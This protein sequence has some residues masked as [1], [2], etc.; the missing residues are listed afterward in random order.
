M[1]KKGYDRMKERFMEHHMA[2]RIAVVLKD[3]LKKSRERSHS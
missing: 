3:V 1:G 2:E